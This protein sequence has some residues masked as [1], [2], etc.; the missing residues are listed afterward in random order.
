[1]SN[2]GAIEENTFIIYIKNNL[3]NIFNYLLNL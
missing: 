2:L 3:A 1:M